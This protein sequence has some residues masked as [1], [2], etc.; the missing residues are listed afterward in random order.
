MKFQLYSFIVSV[1]D[2]TGLSLVL[3]EARKTDFVMSY[4]NDVLCSV[5]LHC[6]AFGL[7]V[8]VAF[9]G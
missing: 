3:P 5:S 6:I 8:I 9:P 7:T 4:C 2:E 1:A